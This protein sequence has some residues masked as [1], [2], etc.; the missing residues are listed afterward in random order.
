MG[1]TEGL[2]DGDAVGDD[3]IAVAAVMT[4]EQICFFVAEAN[5]ESTRGR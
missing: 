3:V 5:T 2:D 4:V 1:D